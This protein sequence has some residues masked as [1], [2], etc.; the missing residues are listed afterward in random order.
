[1]GL[2]GVRAEAGAALLDGLAVGAV[3]ARVVQRLLQRA[4]RHVLPA[5]APRPL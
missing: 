3:A 5:N 4:V 2:D 1:M